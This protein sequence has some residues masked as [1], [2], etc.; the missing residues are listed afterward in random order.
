M[1]YSVLIID[2]DIKEAETVQGFL[3]AGFSAEAAFSGEEAFRY[4][5]KK[6]PDLILL[7]SKVPDINGNS[8]I[9]LLKESI[10]TK[11]VPVVVMLEDNSLE[12][13]TA[14]ISAGAADFVTKPMGEVVL[15]NR[16]RH[17]IETEMYKK[18]LE[19]V[20]SEQNK[21]NINN[22]VKMYRLQQ[23]MIISMA[24]VIESRDGST[25]EHVKRAGIYVEKLSQFMLTE[26]VY[27]EIFTEC[28]VDKLCRAA[29]MHDIGKIKIADDIL[30]KR[31]KLTPEEFEVM[32][33]HAPYGGEIIRKAM[34][35]FEDYEYVDI[36]CDIAAYH[37]EKWDGSGYCKGLKGEEIPLAARV[38]AVAD[39]FDALTSKRYYKD[40]VSAEATFEIMESLVGT[41]FDPVIA[42]V[43]LKYR[44]VFGQLMLELHKN[45]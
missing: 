38:M 1:R 11:D 35:G 30:K 17:I 7:D 19:M 6:Q 33:L 16:I 23:G 8:Y 20:V 9:K 39:V 29:F 26:K 34:E 4:M 21:L 41:Q 45:L 18:H 37:H 28:Y 32:K 22:A 3:R 27:P 36:A 13:E 2:R 15:K 5:E 44:D 25:G 31:D 12:K 24:N 40:E 14:V 10:L 42:N 43:F